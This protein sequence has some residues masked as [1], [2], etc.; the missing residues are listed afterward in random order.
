MSF[1]E[2]FDQKGVMDVKCIEE[3]LMPLLSAKGMSAATTLAEYYEFNHI[4]LHM[5]TTNI[6]GI[7]LEKI[8]MSHATHPS[9]ALVQALSMSMGP[10]RR[11]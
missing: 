8:D 2:A 1:I 3:S 10:V 9:L 6:N 4:D 11:M 5:F 7:Q